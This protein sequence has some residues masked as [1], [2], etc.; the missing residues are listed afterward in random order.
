MEQGKTIIFVSHAPAAV[1]RS[2]A[3]SACSTRGSSPSTATSKA[4]WPSTTG[5]SR[6][7]SNTAGSGSL[8]L[9][10]LRLSRRAGSP[11]RTKRQ[12][13]RRRPAAGHSNSFVGR[14]S[15]HAITCST[16]AA[17]SVAADSRWRL[18]SIRTTTW[19]SK[20]VPPCSSWAKSRSRSTSRWRSRCFRALPF[21]GVARCI[22]SVVRKLQPSGRFYA[23]WFENPDPANFDPIVQPNGVTTYPDHEPYHYPF[24]LIA[25]VC[26]AVGATVDRVSER[27]SPRGRVGPRHLAQTVRVSSLPTVSVLV[28]NLSGRQHLDACFASL[29][30]QIYPRDRREVVLVDDGSTD[31]SIGVGSRERIR[32]LESSGSKR[33]QGFCAAYNAA[34]RSCESDFVALLEQRHPCR[35][36]GGSPSWC[37]RPGVIDAVCRRSRRFSIGPATRSISPDGVTSFI[38]HSWQVDSR[39]AGGARLRRTSAALFT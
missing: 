23:T 15:S 11:H 25:N 5:C 4:G 34:V 36:S 32:A 26:G 14:V 20:T 13:V 18:F 39:R 27:H 37:P 30:A 38:G 8:P 6:T 16:W 28:L 9:A 17:A 12:E 33:H 24:A 31:G 29:D 19:G 35:S 21:N 1:R 7:R 22:A 10:P 3:A 2:A